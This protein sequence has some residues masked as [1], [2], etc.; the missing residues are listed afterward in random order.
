LVVVFAFV[1]AVAPPAWIVSRECL[2]VV[3][4]VVATAIG[5]VLCQGRSHLMTPLPTLFQLPRPTL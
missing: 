2:I 1:V 4:R 5:D 3:T